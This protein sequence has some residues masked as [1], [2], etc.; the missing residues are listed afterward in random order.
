M[1]SE[2]PKAAHTCL[3]A[4]HMPLPGS[5]L[6]T[7]AGLEVKL[8]E[9]MDRTWTSVRIGNYWSNRDDM[10]MVLADLMKMVGVW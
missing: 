1:A 5:I 9:K 6:C 2:S 7:G 8:I 3:E 10:S 4:V